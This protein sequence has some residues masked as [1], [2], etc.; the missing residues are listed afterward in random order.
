MLFQ[1]QKTSPSISSQN[2]YAEY[3]FSG[4][5]DPSGLDAGEIGTSVQPIY[6]VPATEL[7][8][9]PLVNNSEDEEDS[10]ISAK[11]SEINENR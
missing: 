4:F 1:H 10:A 5:D 6:P 8:G 2:T 11:S 7:N 3:D 9:H